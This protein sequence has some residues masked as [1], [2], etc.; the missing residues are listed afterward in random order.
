MVDSLPAQLPG[1]V[2]GLLVD[3]LPTHMNEVLAQLSWLGLKIHYSKPIDTGSI[4]NVNTDN[5]VDA[6]V[7]HEIEYFEKF[8]LRES[9]TR[10]DA[11]GHSNVTFMHMI[12]ACWRQAFKSGRTRFLDIL[13]Q[14]ERDNCRE[15]KLEIQK[16]KIYEH[17]ERMKIFDLVRAAANALDPGHS[18]EDYNFSASTHI[19]Y[20]DPNG[21]PP[22]YTLFEMR[23][24]KC[25]FEHA[26]APHTI[27]WIRANCV[28]QL[29]STRDMEVI[30]RA[31][32]S[33]NI[34]MLELMCN[35]NIGFIPDSMLLVLLHEPKSES[36]ISAI[37]TDRKLFEWFSARQWRDEIRE[38]LFN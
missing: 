31:I 25:F 20:C 17:N 11:A 24:G 4:L 30:E 3:Y 32:E 36:L 15:K 9:A 19:D 38:V 21:Y 7:K 23:N 14:I 18:I 37:K 8:W 16:Q 12:H 35:S 5:L 2:I 26:C 6:I 27:E 33:S 28:F 1:D 22:I 10:Y 29:D 34:L 13:L